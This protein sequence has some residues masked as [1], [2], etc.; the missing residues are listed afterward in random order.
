MH[1]GLA[2]FFAAFF[3]LFFVSISMFSILFFSIAIARFVV[4]VFLGNALKKRFAVSTQRN[5]RHR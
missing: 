5:N 3:M 2:H 1:Y 4:L